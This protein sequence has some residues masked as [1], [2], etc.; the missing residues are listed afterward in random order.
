M[1]VA[2]NTSS[3]VSGHK[4]RGIGFY[5]KYLIEHLKQQKD[6]QVE[7]FCFLNEVTKADVVHY[8]SFDFFFKTLGVS[9]KYP[10]VVTIHDVTPLVFPQ[11][12]PPGIKGRIRFLF[13]KKTVQR[14]QAIITDS[15]ASKK[16][17]EKYLGVK[18]DKIFVTYLA[19]A[20]HFKKLHD[21]KLFDVIRKKYNLPNTFFLFTGNVNWNKN[22]INMTQACIEEEKD[23][24][25]VGGSFD[26]SDNLDHPEMKSYKEFLKRYKNNS[27]VHTFGFVPN[28]DLVVIMNMA[29]ALLLPSF[30]EGFGL[31]ILE[32]QACGT[33]VITSKTSSMPEVA[34]EAALFVDPYKVGSIRGAIQY[35]SSSDI[36]D[37]LIEK[38]YENVK[39]FSWDKC[40]KETID[41][42]K[43]VI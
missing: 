41:V 23:L 43:K 12:Y 16:D 39:R 29:T 25:L 38:G 14:A 6:I 42:Y 10:T 28:E 11:H 13:Q 33:P 35:L 9:S 36:K 20:K 31:T 2:L 32:A 24:V 5:T 37:D 8:P 17:I 15:E 40:A 30:Y 19:P 26:S 21:K 1:R 7:E 22:L 3:L 4:T 34:G 27:L 18:K